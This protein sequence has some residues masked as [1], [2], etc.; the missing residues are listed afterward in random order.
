MTSVK[1]KI[2]PKSKH[3]EPFDRLLRRFKKACDRKGI[4]QECRDRKYY[5]K[6]NDLKNQKNQAIKRKRKLDAKR[7]E[8]N[9][10]RR[11]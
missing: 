6:P 8:S 1:P 2:H 11:R 7:K 9:S 3:V 4:I 5:T 10:Y